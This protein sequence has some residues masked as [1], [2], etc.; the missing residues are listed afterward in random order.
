MVRWSA[1]LG[2]GFCRLGKAVWRIGTFGLVD[3]A[4]IYDE[5]SAPRNFR[6]LGIVNCVMGLILIV[7][8]WLT[9]K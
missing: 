4:S 5:A 3:M 7:I 6:R 1:P 8:A 2:I 9:R